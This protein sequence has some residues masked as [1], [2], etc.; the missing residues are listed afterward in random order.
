M[1]REE[2]ASTT[3]NWNPIYLIGEWMNDESETR[4]SVAILLPSGIGKKTDDYSVSISQDGRSLNLSVKWP[5]AMSS[6]NVM[7]RFWTDGNNDQK[8]RAEGAVRAA[9]FRRPLCLLRKNT[10]RP[11][12]ST[13]TIELPCV[14]KSE[15]KIVE[16]K[17]VVFLRV[18]ESGEKILYLTLETPNSGYQ[19][20]ESAAV[21]YNR[22]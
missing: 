19:V 1:N 18:D 21:Q 13:C 17:N 10:S 6:P 3:A 20:Q 11:I 5:V 9:A 12:M 15:S 16:E 7:H 22:I 14:V 4:I 8:N 2:Y